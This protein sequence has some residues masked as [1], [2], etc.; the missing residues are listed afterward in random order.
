MWNISASD[1][2]GG[3]LLAAPLGVEGDATPCI[4][5]RDPDPQALIRYCRVTCL[6]GLVTA[7]TEQGLRS[8]A[9]R[10]GL[11]VSALECF[12]P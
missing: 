11:H 6:T 10:H 3:V 1:I 5:W 9:R 12:M 8:A 7:E 2:V 4:V